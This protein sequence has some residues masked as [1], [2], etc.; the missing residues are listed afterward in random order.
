MV[1]FAQAQERAEEWVNGELP[2]YQHREVRVREFDLGFVVW[3]EDRAD[4]PRSDGGAQRLVIARDSGEAT[5]WPSLPVGEVI[6]RYEEEYGRPEEAQAPAAAPAARVDLNQTSFLLSPPEWLQEAADRIGIPD[7][8][9]GDG[10]AGATGGAGGSGGALPQTQAGVPA[11]PAASG[12]SPA[13]GSSGSG[14]G[15][16]AAGSGSSAG[17][18]G[19]DAGA[20]GAPSAPGVPAGATPWAGTDTNADAG[21]DR[22]V[23]LPQTVFA[24][25]LSGVDDDTPPPSTTSD[26]KTALMSGGSGLPP[27]AL[28][29][30]IG[31]PNAPGAPA[32]AGTPPPA[33]PT[34]PP[35]QPPAGPGAPATPP[36][37]LAPDAGD[38]ADAATSKATP[39]PRRGGGS[40]TPP[41]P[42]AP[43]MPGARP[44]STPAPSGPPA[45]G[46]PAG[47]YVPTQLVSSLGPEG[48]GGPGTP[49]PPS[50][51]ATPPAPGATPPPGTPGTPP[52]PPPSAPNAP[53]GT[54][55]G[56]MHHA[57]TML[58]DPGRT[59][60]G[61]PQPP[62]PPGPPNPPGPPGP[63]GAPAAP[64]APGAPGVPSGPGVPPPPPG[65]PGAQGSAG[66]AGGAVHHAQTVL[67]APSLG[68]PGGIGAPPPP[69]GAVPPPPGQPVPGQPP[70]YGYPPQPTG[71]PTVGPGYQAVLRYRAQD[72]SEQ[73]LIRRSAPGTPHPEWQ[74]FH[75]LRSMNVPP[76]QVLELHTE[77]ESC[78]LPGAY[79]ARMIREQWPQARI[80]SIAPY[81]LDHASRQQGMGQLLAHQ[82]ELHQVADGPARPAPVRAPLPQV[83]PAPP[84]PPEAVGQ[85]LAGAFGPGVF[86]FEQ[87][88]VSRQGV[89]PVVAHTL[90]AAGLPMDMGP[91]F[92]AQA[93]PG[94]PVPTLAEL[95]A[96]RGVQPASDAGSYLV[97]GSDFGRA[98]CVQYGTAAIVAVPV[99]AG[100]GG[101][102]VPPQFV[103]TGLPEFARCLALLGRMWRLRFGLNQEQAGRWT[104]DFQAQLAALDPAALGSPESWWSVLLEQMWDGLL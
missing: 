80:T 33:A 34:A 23:P 100:P 78:E 7:R 69:P 53:G 99:E 39:P 30:A 92:W 31:D 97:V 36:R 103:N 32:G 101:A 90:V 86:R 57:A 96:E 66:G 102:P 9:R 4:G 13:G 98:I 19:A 79:C 17:G 61:A 21:D 45:P 48:P 52:P 15:W 84:V 46:A 55:P 8:R 44:G 62:G 14:A 40:S 104:V 58:A 81:G 85:E 20:S 65:A 35:A 5:L 73:Q 68:G 75:E 77:L 1:T 11:A 3:A 70:A 64:G 72:G 82:G 83:Q 67:A 63:P 24:P 60:G 89:P 25:P 12:P 94:R 88:A 54:P 47:G 28:S 56:G 6:R 49:P 16:P 38:I 37:P 10:E 27:T 29:P 50:A 74:M 93:Q 18:S 87:A 22:S 95:A 42:S 71:Q 91:F 41:P 43:G 51:P 76:D 26:A 2:A 59:G